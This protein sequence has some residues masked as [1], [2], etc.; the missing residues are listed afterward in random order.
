MPAAATV[1]GFWGS[2][3]RGKWSVV[4][5]HTQPGDLS[6]NQG[7]RPLDRRRHIENGCLG[8]PIRGHKCTHGTRKFPPALISA[9]ADTLQE[10][11]VGSAQPEDQQYPVSVSRAPWAAWYENSTQAVG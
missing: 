1:P 7:S 10:D 11:A 9:L 4:T 3:P 2:T 5:S 6:I 8:F